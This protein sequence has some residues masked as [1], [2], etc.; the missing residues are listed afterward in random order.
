MNKS[1]QLLKYVLLI[2]I[3]IMLA[4]TIGWNRIEL[5]DFNPINGDFQ[6]YNPIRRFLRGQVLE[7]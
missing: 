6:N 2:S 5:S 7:K 4:A 3:L 1:K